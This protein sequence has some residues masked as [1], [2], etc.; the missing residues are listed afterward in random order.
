MT[1]HSKN[2]T[3]RKK[4][5]HRTINAT[6]QSK[7]SLIVMLAILFMVCV[8]FF[9]LDVGDGIFKKGEFVPDEQIPAQTIEQ[10]L[11]QAEII[12]VIPSGEEQAVVQ[13]VKPARVEEG[14]IYPL[15]AEYYP[16]DPAADDELKVKMPYVDGAV[17]APKR[18][19]EYALENPSSEKARIAIMIDDVGMNRE[20]SRAVVDISEPLTL[21]FL[22]YAPDLQSLTEPALKMGH[23][24]MIHMPMIN[25]N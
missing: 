12:D 7:R 13:V 22:P 23:E 19:F 11:G 24:L 17:K 14:Y 20:Q 16:Y 21:A 10:G 18:S 5:H 9:V 4:L 6:Y 1:R 8:H 15:F 25:L 3:L 2:K